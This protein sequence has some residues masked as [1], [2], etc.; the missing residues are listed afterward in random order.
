MAR[1]R[2]TGVSEATTQRL[3]LLLRSL[4]ELEREGVGSVSSSELAERL[5]SNSAQVRKDLAQLGELGVRGVGYR[6]PE[7]RTRIEGHTGLGTPRTLVVV[8]AGNLGKALA[9]SPN[10][11]SEGFRIAAVFDVDPRKVGGR[12]RTG[13]P[14]LDAARLDAAVRELGAAIG[15]VAVP[16]PAARAA[17]DSLVAA[18]VKA[19]LNF[20][21]HAVGPYPGVVVKNVD[22]TLL[23]ETLGARL[24]AS[25]A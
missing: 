12:T 2:S 13:V 6:V 11:H 5:G 8:G 10:F 1:R 16:A 3:S 15:V 20:A 23:V 19:I 9:D 14:V 21:P 22:L 17:A 18:G 24:A 25:G 7:L 4:R